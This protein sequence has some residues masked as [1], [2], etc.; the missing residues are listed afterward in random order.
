MTEQIADRPVAVVTG[1][2]SGFGESIVREL[3]A[4]WGW[5][6]VAV[7]RREDRLAELVDQVG[8]EYVVCDITDP[9]QVRDMAGIIL[10]RHGSIDA[11]INCAGEPMR[12]HL[13]EADPYEA[14]RVMETNY[15]GG[16]RVVQ[17][18]RP[19]LEAAGRADVIDVVSAAATVDNPNSGAYSASKKAQ[20]AASRMM[21]SDL[22]AGNIAVHSVLPGKADTEG[23]PQ[24]PSSSPISRLTRTDVET[25]T[26]AVL[27]RIGRRPGEIHVPRILKAVGIA[28][29][30]APVTVGRIVGKVLS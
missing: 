30:L 6:T 11:L 27:G 16:V 26:R 21:R 22:R 1:A 18:L 28:N 25:V 12:E 9:D 14:G 4:D 2:S 24:A 19:G 8:G 23:H 15:L 5:S 3:A 17:A 7:A 20:L 10:G 29:D 13:G